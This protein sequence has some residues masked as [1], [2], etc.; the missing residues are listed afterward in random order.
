MLRSSLLGFGLLL[1]TTHSRIITTKDCDE[2]NRPFKVIKDLTNA[3]QKQVQNGIATVRDVREIIGVVGKPDDKVVL[4]FPEGKIVD[5]L[6]LTDYSAHISGSTPA[7]QSQMSE[8]KEA[9]V[10]GEQQ[11]NDLNQTNDSKRDMQENEAST[12]YPLLG[13]I[14]GQKIQLPS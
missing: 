7:K 13:S 1:M 9:V 4:I 14:S 6:E 5:Q 11:T 2:L 10:I 12:Y 3:F 8:E